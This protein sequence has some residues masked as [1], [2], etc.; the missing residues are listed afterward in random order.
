MVTS[1]STRRAVEALDSG[2]DLSIALTVMDDGR[3]LWIQTARE[4]D[5]ITCHGDQNV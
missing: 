1:D 2:I 3:R 4:F 5:E